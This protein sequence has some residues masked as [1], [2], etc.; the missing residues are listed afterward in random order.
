MKRKFVPLVLFSVAALFATGLHGQAPKKTVTGTAI[1]GT[2]L[3]VDNK[4]VSN[5]AVSCESSGGLS[6]HIVHSDSKGRFTIT[7]LKQDSYDIR[8]S[9]GGAYSDWQRNIPLRKGQNKNV[10]LHLKNGPAP[11]AAA[12]VQDTKP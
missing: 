9:A 2:V 10:T 8:A 3:G 4:P 7:G 5:A 6:P 1:T 11:Q 12:P